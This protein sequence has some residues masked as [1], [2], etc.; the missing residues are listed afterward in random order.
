MRGEDKNKKKINW[1]GKNIFSI[2]GIDFS[3]DAAHMINVNYEKVF[4]TIERLVSQWSKR[5]LTVLGKISII[6]SLLLPK[7]IHM[8]LSLPNP[9]TE[10]VTRINSLFYRFI[11][12][13][14][15]DKIS[16]QQMTSD[17][18][19]GGL[20][21]V[22]LNNFFM[23]LKITWLRRM[24]LSTEDNPMFKLFMNI[25]NIYNFFHLETDCKHLS[26]MRI[27][28]KTPFWKEVMD[29]WLKFITIHRPD[30][31]D[32]LLRMQIWHNEEIKIGTEGVKYATWS[33]AG[34][35]FIYDLFNCKG[36]F[37]NQKEIEDTYHIK[38]N[39]LQFLGIKRLIVSKFGNLII[40]G[41]EKPELPCFPFHIKT[42]LDDKKGCR[43]IYDIL[44]NSKLN[45]WKSQK[46]W[47]NENIMYNSKEWKAIYASPH[48]CTMD[49]KI[50]YFQYK[51]INRIVATN[52]LLCK[53]G[54]KSNPLCSF[55]DGQV[56][57][58]RHLF[59]SCPVVKQIWISLHNQI[60]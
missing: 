37:M 28:M 22:D 21:M 46:R 9:S 23:A 52:E 5:N 31:A 25:T 2:L 17:Y 49:T 4:L 10:Y 6:K 59:C 7:L 44:N 32:E 3:L 54:I 35:L 8:I 16:R 42:L 33:K 13:N 48:T 19:H 20:R 34:I 58:I 18:M 27:N 30:S 60:F 1:I 29:A 57:S 56:E 11:W 14:K 12:Q 40:S 38:I 50:V 47:K 41:C 36:Q 43:N 45:T 26:T 55:G 51:V 15:P 53:M 39:Y 24:F